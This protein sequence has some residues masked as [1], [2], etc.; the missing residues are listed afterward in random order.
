LKITTTPPAGT[1]GSPVTGGWNI[2][3]NSS[4]AAVAA[5]SPAISLADAS[6][7]PPQ[8][9]TVV[10]AV[11][12]DLTYYV[13]FTLDTNAGPLDGNTLYQLDSFSF[14]IK[15][16]LTI[17]SATTGAGTGKA[18]FNPLELVLDQSS[19]TPALFQAL[20]AGTLFKQVDVLGYRQDG[21]LATDDSFGLAFDK[22]L[23][24]NDQGNTDVSLDYGRLS[25]RTYSDLDIGTFT[26]AT[27]ATVEQGQT[28]V[29][30]TVT[31]G[32]DGE[33]LALTQTAGNGTL[34]LG[35]VSNGVQQVIYTA[36]TSI[37]ASA[38]DAVSFTISDQFNDTVTASST[39]VQLDAGPSITPVLP[40]VVEK[41]QTTEVGAVTPGLE[42]DT[43]TLKQT[44][45]SGT[46]ALQLV[47]DVEEVIYTAPSA[48]AA[49]TQDA[50]SYTISDQYNDVMPSG[51]ATVQL[52]AGPSIASV[53]PSVVEKSQ[54]TE[55]GTVT[56]GLVGDTLTLKQTG[57]S[58][59]LALKLVNGVEEVIY[60]APSAIAASIVDAVSYTVS[61]QHN[62]AMA[63]GSAD[64]Q[65]DAGPTAANTRLYLAPGRTVDLTSELL[66]LAKPGLPQDTLTLSAVGTNNTS[67][68]V[69]LNN[70]DLKYTAPAR[71]NL[72]GFTYTVSDE[73]Q[74]SSTAS[75]SVSIS[76]SLNR[77]AD[78]A[79]TGSGNIVV[80]GDGKDT[81]TGGTG[82]N[83]VALGNGDDTVSLGGSGNVITLG[84][85]DDKIPLAGKENI[86]TAGNGD[87][88]VT[89]GT[90]NETITL[91]NGRDRV[92]TSGLNN[93]ITVGSGRD[94]VIA[95]SGMDTVV[96]GNG[97]DTI[98]LDGAGNVV[99]A[100]NGRDLVTGGTGNETITLGNG[101]DRVRR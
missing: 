77:N 34:S 67:G 66:A 80:G 54:T 53:A 32:F 76:S 36:P 56:P 49:S 70:G 12:P 69:S 72:D 87:D 38:A 94:L 74:G 17:G 64:V 33:T 30:G 28:T 9:K 59:T 62:D 78:I 45:G 96:A 6:P 21:T 91:G 48:I 41:G 75:V 5:A 27:P 16:T 43:L 25:I 97:R 84:N 55:V 83:F 23:S 19:L 85:G 15:N 71:G 3:T 35:Q 4:D 24:T 26:A 52:D 47:N 81:V 68:A 63:M 14:D 2:V 51:S 18:V 22:D 100:G 29:I 99:N 101:R 11:S 42:G 31:L 7:T 8:G 89:G 73:H 93:T 65:L 39:S 86:V 92:L 57:G 50:V 58:G 1:T 82:N 20:A 61:D 37:T 95:G 88:V 40:S 90:G 98:V 46:L 79:L 44:G 60:T 13:R 10:P